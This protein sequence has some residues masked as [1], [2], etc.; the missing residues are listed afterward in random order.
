M[1]HSIAIMIALAIFLL[2]IALLRGNWIVLAGPFSLW[3]FTQIIYT[4]MDKDTDLLLGTS[5]YQVFIM[6]ILWLTVIYIWS[7]EI[8]GAYGANQQYLG[9]MTRARELVK[10]GQYAEAVNCLEH[11][12]LPAYML[13]LNAEKYHDLGVL[14]LNAGH[15]QKAYDY[16]SQSLSY[17]QTNPE[18]C[19]LLA[20]IC[21]EQ[22]SYEESMAWLH[23]TKSFNYNPPKMDALEA[24]LIEKLEK[25]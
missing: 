25:E 12:E 9:E 13:Q 23:L 21:C 15:N 14:Y 10:C 5:R 7:I 22:E 8:K 20:C 24:K 1:K 16:L 4:N 19:Y 17:N 18:A 6:M 11:I 3:I 2:C